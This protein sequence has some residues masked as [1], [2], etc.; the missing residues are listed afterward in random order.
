MRFEM[1]NDHFELHHELEQ[2]LEFM[3]FAVALTGFAVTA[4]P[5]EISTILLRQPFLLQLRAKQM[6]HSM[7]AEPILRDSA[8]MRM[9]LNCL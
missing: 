7:S 6:P 5:R 1:A 4:V 8:A 3:R 9:G 2:G